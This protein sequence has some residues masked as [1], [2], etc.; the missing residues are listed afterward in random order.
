LFA[1]IQRLKA[2]G[3]T[4]VYISHRMEEVFHLRNRLLFRLFEELP[5][6]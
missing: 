2:K 3:V 4:I 5:P 6:D 1:L